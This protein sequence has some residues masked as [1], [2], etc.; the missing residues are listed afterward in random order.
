MLGGKAI[1]VTGGGSG[2]GRTT[3]LCL[4][5]DGAKVTVADIDLAAAQDCVAAI[6]AEG[7]EAQ[8]VY[9]D[10]ADE[11]S[12]RAMVDAAVARYC[13]LDGAF[14]N[15]G[16]EMHGKQLSDLNAAEWARVRSIDLDG[17]FYCMKHEISAMRE[18]GGGAIVNTASVAAV[19]AQTNMADYCAAKAGVTGLTRAAAAEFP[20]TKVRANTVLPGVILTPMVKDRLLANPEME[21]VFAP[22]VERHSVGR[23]GEPEDV[24]QAVRWLLSDLSA[25]V[26]GVAL[27]VDGGYTAR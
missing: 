14:N 21:A 10:V 11:A 25:Y 8:A 12:V 15:A 26:N 9:C 22:L 1:I 24:A 18:T 4:G 17:V 6:L 2:I 3:A 13:K 23:F 27:P 16:V 7:G 19:T 5:R 20:Q